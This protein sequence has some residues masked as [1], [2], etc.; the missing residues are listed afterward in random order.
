MFDVAYTQV[1]TNILVNFDVVLHLF[2]K[3]EIKFVQ[4]KIVFFLGK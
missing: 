1:P 2:E 3:A 4:S